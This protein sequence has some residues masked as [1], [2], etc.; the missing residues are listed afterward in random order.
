MGFTIKTNEGDPSGHSLPGIA[1]RRQPARD[2][3]IRPNG[4]T[5]EFTRVPDL[6]LE[7]WLSN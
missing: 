3:A 1:R 2:F 4:N 6:R 5:G 7:H